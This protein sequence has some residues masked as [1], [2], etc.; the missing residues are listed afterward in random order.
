MS[1]IHAVLDRNQLVSRSRRRSRTKV[2]GTPLST[3]LG[4]NDLWCTDYRSEFQL[5]NKQ[6]CYPLTVTDY[7]SRY[8]L[9]C[10]AMESNREQRIILISR[11]CS[12]G[13][14]S[15]ALKSSLAH[16]IMSQQV[17]KPVE[18]NGVDSKI[19]RI[20]EQI[21]RELILDQLAQQR[22]QMA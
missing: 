6:Y 4:P 14:T 10:E 15:S 13:K 16:P 3:G 12:R 17:P 5:G 20:G 11:Y 19:M 7:C 18:E 22:Q 8:F 9:L 21:L 1:T 2:E